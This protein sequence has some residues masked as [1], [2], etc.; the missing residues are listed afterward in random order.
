[1]TFRILLLLPMMCLVNPSAA[2]AALGGRIALYS[3]AGLSECALTDT[4]PGIVDIYV[5]H[6]LQGYPG[7]QQAAFAL[8][9]SAG[10]NGTWLEDIVPAGLSSVGASP[11]G[12]YILSSTCWFNDRL[13]LHV[14]YQMQGGSPSCSFL[15][16]VP[17]PDWPWIVAL[18]CGFA[19]P[20]AVDGS[21]IL[22]NPD[23]SCPC[24]SPVATESATWGRIKAMYRH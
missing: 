23:G 11:S 14:R 21:R 9:P 13:L 8:A 7:A 10:F 12:I 4:N 2:H 1:M 16:A 5:V 18:S 15:A 24:E 6:R 17:H 19:E 3:D 22:V 20:I